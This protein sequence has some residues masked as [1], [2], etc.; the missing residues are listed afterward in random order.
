MVRRRTISTFARESE[1]ASKLI[2]RREL[3]VHTLARD[4]EFA[5]NA[6]WAHQAIFETRAPTSY[7]CTLKRYVPT[8]PLARERRKTTSAAAKKDGPAGNLQHLSAQAKREHP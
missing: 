4:G 5:S 3:T 1:S 8:H 2:G 7:K 6:V